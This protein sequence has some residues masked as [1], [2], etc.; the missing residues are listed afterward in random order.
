MIKERNR[1]FVESKKKIGYIPEG[2]N[3]YEFGKFVKKSKEKYDPKNNDLNYSC[4]ELEH[5]NQQIGSINGYIMAKDQLS[6]KN[7]F[8]T[9]E[10]L[11]SKL[12]P[13]L[14]KYWYATFDGV[15][16][17]EIWVLKGKNGM[18]SN[19]YLFYLIQT[20]VFNRI[21][22]ITSG[23]K[24]PRADWDYIS[25]FPFLLPSLPEQNKITAILSTWDHAIQKN[26]LLK[27]AK[28][29]LKK[30][31]LQK[32]VTGKIRF[33][34]FGEGWEE[35]ELKQFLKL[36]LRPINKPTKP[37]NALGIRS[38][39][40]GTFTK[41]IEDPGKISMDTLYEVKKDDFIVNITFAWEGAVA[42]VK[43]SDEGNLVSHRFPT[44]IFDTNIVLPD[45]FKYIILTRK[46]IYKLGTIS[47]GGAGRNRVLSK[48]N[49]L[50]LKLLIP[51]IEE[52]KKIVSILSTIDNEIDLLTKNLNKLKQQKKGL[53]QQLLTGN[54]RVKVDNRKEV[55]A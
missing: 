17:S 20:D 14:Q 27:G 22:N 31:L 32:M 36:K 42:I 54:I 34:E 18:I 11:Y 24:M 39:G 16:S 1:G 44:Y 41:Y 45:Y 30:E 33:P 21:A 55:S 8:K 46:F 9:G 19:K 52:Q 49:L 37:Y 6:I 25:R 50:K 7:K 3:I 13:Y 12:R 48:K 26:K 29:C 47:P 4:I 43:E 5:L 35:Y 10:V 28:Q 53:M 51:E 40:K 38:H 15:C 23:T 2:W